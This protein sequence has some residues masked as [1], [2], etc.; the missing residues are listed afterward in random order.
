ML[1]DTVTFIVCGSI[2]LDTSG[3]S[4]PYIAGWG[5]DG[6]LDAIRSYAQTIDTV[7]KRIEGALARPTPITVRHDRFSSAAQARRTG[8]LALAIHR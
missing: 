2:G 3:S 6:Q 5:E 1:V 8:W 7:A 4:V